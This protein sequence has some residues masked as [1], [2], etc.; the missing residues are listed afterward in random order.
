[1]N[2]DPFWL[3]RLRRKHSSRKKTK[4]AI[5][6]TRTTEPTTMP[7]IAPPDSPFF[8]LLA[9]AEVDGDEVDVE[10]DVVVG[11]LVEKVMYPVIVGSLTPAH[12]VSAPE[13]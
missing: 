12:L 5:I 11:R 2:I 8:E 10:V 9:T 4:P 1:M 3:P 13:L 7:A 6:A